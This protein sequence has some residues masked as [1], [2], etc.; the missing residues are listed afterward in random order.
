MEAEFCSRLCVLRWLDGM[1]SLSTRQF[2]CCRRESNV[3]DLKL[4]KMVG[5]GVSTELQ[6]RIGAV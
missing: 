4:T 1:F 6:E 2:P 5:F 3:V